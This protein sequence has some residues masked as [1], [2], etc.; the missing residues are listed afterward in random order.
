[1]ISMTMGKGITKSTLSIVNYLSSF[2]NN[3]NLKTNQNSLKGG[4]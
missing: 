4:K 3:Y 1:M 2:F